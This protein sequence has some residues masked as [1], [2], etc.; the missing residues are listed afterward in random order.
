MENIYRPEFFNLNERDQRERYNNLLKK[1]NIDVFDTISVQLEELIKIQNP[2]KRIKREEFNALIKMHLGDI[3]LNNYGVWV[4]YPWSNRIV[5]LLPEE[6]FIK[7]R[8]NRNRNRITTEEQS[9]LREKKIGVVGLSVGQSIA[10]TMAMERICGT[11]RLADYDFVELCNLNR[12]RTGVHNLGISKTVL[13]AREISEIDPFI[14]VEVF[15]DGLHTDN[16]KEFITE[17]GGLDM[18]VEVCDNMEIKV[19]SRVEARKYHVPVV[20]ETNDRCMVDIERFDL[21]PDRPILHGR[22]TEKDA[23]KLSNLSDD[24]R[25]DLVSRIVD[26]D[27]LSTRMKQSFGEIGKTLNAWPQLASSVTMGG[28]VVTEIVRRILLDDD[29]PSGRCYL[30]I[31][32]ILLNSL[33]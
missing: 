23:K 30:D 4:Y 31:E 13:A 9:S 24:E 3:E 29:I 1:E 8:T 17:N 16:I 7:V 26:G 6:E 2:D 10:L 25:L 28:G 14:E 33:R 20:M 18:M 12:I 15:S 5:H 21:E 27:Q 11:L 32:D 19:K 22:V